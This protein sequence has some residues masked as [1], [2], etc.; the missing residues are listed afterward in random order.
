M[1]LHLTIQ[2]A[3]DILAHAFTEHPF[4]AGGI[5]PGRDGV[6]DRHVPMRNVSDKPTRRFAVDAD[7]QLDLELAW[8]A[9]GER[10]V[11]VWH[12]HTA[13]E[14]QPSATDRAAFHDPN[15]HYLIV[16]TAAHPQHPDRL[17]SW[18]LVDGELIEEV[19]VVA[20]EVA[21]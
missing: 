13:S 17:R 1:T 18:R 2:L 5:L 21:A 14:A 12:S 8:D 7:R 20:G 15:I 10:P 9:D 16:T 4:E 19:V 11:V 3:A 6:P